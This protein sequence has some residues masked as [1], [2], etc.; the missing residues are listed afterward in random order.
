MRWLESPATA[1]IIA[2]SQL[3]EEEMR[4]VKLRELYKVI[5]YMMIILPPE[6]E[7]AAT[8]KIKDKEELGITTGKVCHLIIS[9]MREN[10]AQEKT[11]GTATRNRTKS[12][13]ESDVGMGGA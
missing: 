7:P 8:K 6:L 5:N 1:S 12:T 3:E 4:K 10:A 2:I 9:R 13:W 11:V